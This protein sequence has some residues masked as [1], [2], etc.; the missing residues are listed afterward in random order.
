[1]KSTPLLLLVFKE[2]YSTILLVSKEEYS[3]IPLVSKE[4]YFTNS[5]S[6]QVKLLH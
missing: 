3:I 1:M 2:E 6:L 4:E 5:T